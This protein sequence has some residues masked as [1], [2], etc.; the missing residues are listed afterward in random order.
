[1]RWEK[2]GL[3]YALNGRQ[4]W[5]VTHTQL[6]IAHPLDAERLRIY[7]GSRT[8]N[9]CTLPT[10]LEADA[11]QPEKITYVHDR[12]LM[13]LGELGTFD[14]SGVMP[15][16]IVEDGGMTYLYYIGWNQGVTVG[17]RNSI[18]LA[19]SDDGGR[20]FTRMFKG[21]IVD[22]T[23]TEPHFCAAP[24][25]LIERGIWRMW[26]L[27]CVKWIVYKGVSEPFYHIKY[28]ESDDGIHW[29]RRGIVSIDFKSPDEAGIVR[30]SVIKAERYYRMWYSYR[31]YQDYRTERQHSYRIG[32]A[33]SA[34][35]VL[36]ERLDEQA[37]IDVSAD[38][39]DSTMLAYPYVYQYK[40]QL[41]MLYNGNGFGQSGFGYAVLN[42]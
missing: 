17:Y 20:S 3:I 27:S 18:G 5:M 7:F 31:N 10:Y 12:P 34:D 37:G 13:E 11:E 29:K 14:D 9:N 19:V 32:Y 6:P 1:M 28:A 16:W 41:R 25:V 38:G 39:W 26:Y 40:G 33:E 36:W 8:A 22:R 23:L 30:A 42:E 35:G 15:S 4:G 2:K 24:C 21:P